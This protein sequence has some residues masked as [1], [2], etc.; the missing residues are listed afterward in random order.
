[1]KINIPLP[2]L[3]QLTIL[4]NPP[5]ISTS[6]PYLEHEP[7]EPLWSTPKRNREWTEKFL[8]QA[9]VVGTWSDDTL[10]HVQD[11]HCAYYFLLDD[12]SEVVY[13]VRYKLE[14]VGALRTV[15]QTSLWR[16]KDYVPA[17]AI[18]SY[19]FFQQLLPKYN[20]ILSDK[21]QSVDGKTFWIRRCG[22]AIRQ[23]LHVYLVDMRDKVVQELSS[24]SVRDKKLIARIWSSTDKEYQHIR[25][26][27][28]KDSI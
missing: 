27:I 10:Y 23:G 6:M 12:N 19:V 14:L 13:A 4:S 20:A 26:L 8:P 18:A 11:K 25:L 1:M 9:V 15:C 24:L 21:S 3:S 7:Y 16:E 2:D 28:S 5:L 22:E 17:I